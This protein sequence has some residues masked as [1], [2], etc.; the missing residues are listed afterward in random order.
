MSVQTPSLADAEWLAAPAVRRV[1]A[2]LNGDGKE[3][4]VV[5][6]AV[7]NALM[8]L[9]LA[10]ID[11]CTTATPD[12]VA[13]RAEAAGIKVAPTGVEHGTLTLVVAGRPFEVTTLREDVETDGRRAVVRFGS[14]WEADAR[15][16]DFTVNAL[17]VD[18][19]GTVYD[20]VGG[21]GDI[22]AGRIR[23][24]GD[25]DRR[26]AEDRLRILRF[27]R[28][29][30]DYG[31]GDIDADGLAAV[32]RARNDLRQLSA[33][34]IGQEMRRLVVA[35]RAVE[36][37]T[38]M[39]EAGVLPV[40]FAGIGY[41]AAFARLTR[42][43]AV[44]GL[45]PPVP[46]RLAAL[47]CRIEEDVQRVSERLRLANAERDRMSRAIAAARALTPQTTERGA[48]AIL[49]R[50]GGEAYR[51]GVALAVAWGVAP[52]DDPRFGDLARLPDRWPVPTFPLSGRDV[53]AR[54][55]TPGPAVGD[56]LAAVEAW[57]IEE[58]FVPDEAALRQ[59]LQQLIAAAQ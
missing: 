6:G 25:P 17:S 32:M 49:Y 55:H 15:R 50:H 59:R 11:F 24:I 36:A 1:F 33:E 5:G 52:A 14:D 13:A 31:R 12:Q 46:V 26:I 53:I 57:W 19:D 39:Q 44:A 45:T 16:R 10:D 20:P 51:D 4:R 43:E 40:V 2:V 8:G 21:Y 34:R 42:F 30:A 23:F 18:A 3:A 22:V 38:L 47:A 58:D 37:V 9:P 54:G 29:Y 35:P 48:R 41:L 28:F 56:L 7:R 27:F